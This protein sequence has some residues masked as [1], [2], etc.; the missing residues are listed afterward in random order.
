MMNGDVL[1][2]SKEWTRGDTATHGIVIALHSTN[3]INNIYPIQVDELL[4]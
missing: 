4:L 2:L 1:Q 3:K